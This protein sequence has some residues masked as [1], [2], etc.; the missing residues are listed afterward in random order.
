MGRFALLSRNV[1]P[2]VF[3][4]VNLASSAWSKKRSV[5]SVWA[6]PTKRGKP[7]HR[8]RIAHF[9]VE[10]KD[11]VSLHS[12]HKGLIEMNKVQFFSANPL[13]NHFVWSSWIWS[14]DMFLWFKESRSVFPPWQNRNLMWFAR[15]WS[16]LTPL[17]PIHTRDEL[18]LSRITKQI[19]C[20][21]IHKNHFCGSW[22]NWCHQFVS[23]G[24]WPWGC[25]TPASLHVTCL[26]SLSIPNV[27]HFLLFFHGR[28]FVVAYH[29]TF[30][31]RHFTDLLLL[32]IVLLGVVMLNCALEV[33]KPAPKTEPAVNQSL[34]VVFC[35]S[36]VPLQDHS[37]MSLVTCGDTITIDC[38]MP[39]DR[40]DSHVT[41]VT[42]TFPW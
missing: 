3:Y 29:Y 23:G 11:E 37:W 35:N 28:A 38:P 33:E 14:T 42:Q 26:A 15:P 20:E 17:R 18:D 9:C 27:W 25:G 31:T 13:L 4:N 41:T 19:W 21:F 24:E 5:F 1:F 2:P 16:R 34:L 40:H 39:L 12:S 22:M 8:I 10:V 36:I 7:E 30:V 6:R 32:H